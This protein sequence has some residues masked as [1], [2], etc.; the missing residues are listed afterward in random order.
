MNDWHSLYF[1]YLYNFG[2]FHDRR[3]AVP[4]ESGWGFIDPS[5]ELV[6]PGPYTHVSGFYAGH[7]RVRN[8]HIEQLTPRGSMQ[9]IT[10]DAVINTQGEIVWETNW[11]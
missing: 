5:G 9:V 7:A 8:E 3:A 2:E 1:N 4:V 11:D 10:Y 6:I